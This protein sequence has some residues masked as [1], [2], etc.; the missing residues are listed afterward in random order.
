M[1]ERF[2]TYRH[3]RTAAI[4]QLTDKEIALYDS[5]I[6]QGRFPTYDEQRIAMRTGVV[7]FDSAMSKPESVSPRDK[8]ISEQAQAWKQGR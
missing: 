8:F 6:E 2:E 7:M 3:G 1:G 5:C 4:S